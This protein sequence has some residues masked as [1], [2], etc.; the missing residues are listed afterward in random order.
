MFP[1][2]IRTNQNRYFF[3]F[4]LVAA[5]AAMLWIIFPYIGTILFSILTVIL[6]YPLYLKILT[7]FRGREILATSVTIV[8]IFLIV[9]IPLAAAI[10]LTINQMIVIIRDIT[11]FFKS[12]DLSLENIVEM[13]NSIILALPGNMTFT[14]IT[15][16]DII[17]FINSM[18]QPAS[19]FII[20][21]A[22]NVLEFGL[23][24][25]SLISH[26]LIFI[27]N[28]AALFPNYSRI[29]K[30]IKKISPL[31]EKIDE[32]YSTRII[33]MIDSM[34]KGTFIIAFIQ[35][36]I[37][38]VF[39]WIAGV[40]Y[41]FF[42]A[43]LATL[44]SI[45]PVGSGFVTIPLGVY[46]ILIGDIWQ[47]VMLILVH[48]FFVSIIDN[49]LRPKLVSKDAQ[50]PEALI[51]LSIVGGV[52]TMGFFGIIYGPIILIIFYTTL[53]VYVKYYSNASAILPK[54]NPIPLQQKFVESNQNQPPL[55]GQN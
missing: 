44:L 17:D 13:I 54:L 29:V 38:G 36:A 3:Y 27:Y 24:S 12:A 46:L 51:L 16:Q 55:E 33:A 19:Q 25:I 1:K 26:S 47:G 10:I 37:S 6:F 11:D 39:Y 8:I 21:Q 32:I 14:Q 42:W 45:I 53:E 34:A 35:G 49:I 43:F 30:F 28:L 7:L 48:V 50:L 23:N 4:L 2:I 40:P 18:I 52:S 22:T 31:D 9:L 15:E 5:S 41:L 20:G